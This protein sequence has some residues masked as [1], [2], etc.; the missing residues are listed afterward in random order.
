M[1]VGVL[2]GVLRLG[3]SID[4]M[5]CE[6]TERVTDRVSITNVLFVPIAMAVACDMH[7]F[8]GSYGAVDIP[9][10]ILAAR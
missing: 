9:A 2:I 8:D 10:Q 1:C 4:E 3:F 7:S 6:H 5:T